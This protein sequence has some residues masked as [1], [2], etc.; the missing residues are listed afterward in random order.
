MIRTAGALADLVGAIGTD[1]FA[2]RFL[3]AL[4]SLAEVDL[5]SVFVRGRR[6]PL[7]LLFAEGRHPINAGFP[8]RAS[9]DYIRTFWRSD[10]RIAAL[11]R[12]TGT[13]PVV[14]RTSAAEI[15][16]PAWRAACYE[17]GG[18]AERVSIVRAGNPAFVANGY[19]L[20]GSA[21]FTA[22]DLERIEAHSAL[23]MAAVERH[24]HACSAGGPMLGETQ[25]EIA[26]RKQLSHGSVVT[27]RRRAY[28]KLGIDNRRALLRLHQRLMAGL[29][30]GASTI[31][32]A[33]IGRD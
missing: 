29:P 14:V 30:P 26:C 17:R 15:S 4:G 5:C 33:M 2:A 10:R 12:S 9:L 27:Y 11:T 31:D 7:R 24:A 8:M 16:D 23:L 1:A 20:G 13:S 6:Q 28:G 3:D 21:G 19:R 18:V 32:T 25:E 22:V